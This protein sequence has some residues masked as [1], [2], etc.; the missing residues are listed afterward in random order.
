VTSSIKPE[1]HNVAQRR[2]RSTEPRPQ[3]IWAK[4]FARIGPAV[5]E[6]CSR[7]DRHT[8]RQTDAQ[9]DGLNTILRTPTGSEQKY[10]LPR[11]M[12]THY[13]LFKTEKPIVNH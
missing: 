4:N 11:T 10:M 3:G 12:Y 7:T 5:P 9:T 6:I 8:H 13:S 1:V 2:R